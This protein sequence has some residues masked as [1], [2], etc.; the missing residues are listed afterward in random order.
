MVTKESQ[1]VHRVTTIPVTL[2][3][4]ISSERIIVAAHDFSDRRASVFPA[5]SKRHMTVHSIGETTADVT[6]G[7]RIGPFV[8]WE[9]CTYDWS[10]PGTVTATVTDSNVYAFPGSKWEIAAVATDEGSRVDMTWT[11]C[12]QRRP[13]ARVMGFMYKRIGERSFSKYGRDVVKNMEQLEKE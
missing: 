6:E 3:T 12:F 9:R 1:G 13:L 7:S 5:V 8:V 4:V 11:R 2:D 10:M